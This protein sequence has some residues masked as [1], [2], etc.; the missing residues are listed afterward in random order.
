VTSPIASRPASGLDHLSSQSGTEDSQDGAGY[1][2]PVS[3]RY[4]NVEKEIS[5]P[6]P[7]LDVASDLVA[8]LA[9]Q[10]Q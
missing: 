9:S 1:W 5:S 2:R 7:F 10:P 6:Y 4:R 3:K 8:Q